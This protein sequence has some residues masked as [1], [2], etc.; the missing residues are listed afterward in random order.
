MLAL[1]LPKIAGTIFGTNSAN[2]AD[3]KAF[4]LDSI[5]VDLNL[6]VGDKFEGKVK[7]VAHFGIF[8]EI[9]NGI[10]GLIH[11]SKLARKGLNL[12]DFSEGQ[13]VSVE[14]VGINNDKIELGLS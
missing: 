10:D 2:L 8:V 1:T 3:A 4:I 5:S 9:K 11:S 14:I 6:K 13:S 12:G 7:K